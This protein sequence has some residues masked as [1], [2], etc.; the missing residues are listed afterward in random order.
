MEA[1]A[2]VRQAPWFSL[3]PSLLLLAES[4]RRP[5]PSLVKSLRVKSLGASLEELRS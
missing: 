4:V 5:Q 2:A 1:F 3:E